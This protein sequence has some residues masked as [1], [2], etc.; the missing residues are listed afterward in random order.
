MLSTSKNVLSCSNLAKLTVPELKIVLRYLRDKKHYQVTLSGCKEDLITRLKS[1]FDLSG[2]V[3][4][5]HTTK[6]FS[7]IKLSQLCLK[8]LNGKN[9]PKL[10]LSVSYANWKFPSRVA[11]WRKDSRIKHDM[12]IP[13][14]NGNKPI[15]WF[16]IP[17]YSKDRNELFV[18]KIDPHHLLTR[19]RSALCKRNIGSARKSDFLDVAKEN[20]TSLKLGMMEDSLDMQSTDFS[21]ITFS[22][23]VEAE[24]QKKGY[25]ASANMCH[26]IRQWFESMD[27]PGISATER[28]RM[29]FRYRDV[30][31]SMTD[32]SKFPP[33]GM[34][35]QGYPKGLWESTIASI[36][37]DII[38]YGLV[39]RRTYNQRAVSSQLCESLFASMA[40]MPGTKNGVPN[41]CDLET[42]FAKICGEVVV[43]YDP[44]S[45]NT[46]NIITQ[47]Y[48][49]EFS[50]QNYSVRSIVRF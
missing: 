14:V 23:E 41:C 33:P 36:D 43:R 30:L 50:H 45:E 25:T 9:Y 2:E 20:K 44:N 28:C 31:L 32:L 7:P 8:V 19:H 10:A 27:N 3:P 4:V 22:S 17:E 11:E 13:E 40:T 46:E 12:V 6:K 39:R 5:I 37:A 16:Y 47:L 26:A 35:V 21:L 38:L 15:N 18:R 42:D 1:M 49:N 24:L 29:K 48:A 34:Y